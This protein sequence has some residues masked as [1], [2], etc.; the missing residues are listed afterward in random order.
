MRYGEAFDEAFLFASRLHRDQTRKQSE[1]P[2]ITHLLAVAALVGEAGGTETEIIAAL[3]HDAVEDQ[4]GAPIAAEIERRFGLDVARIVLACTDT[5]QT[6]KP[7]WRE[8][9]AAFLERLRQSDRSVGLV[10]AADKLH[11][12]R[13]TLEELQVKGESVWEKFTTGR[14]GSLWYYREVIDALESLPAL[15]LLPLLEQTVDALEGWHKE[16]L[17]D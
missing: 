11:N 2:Y 10:V 15:P 9:K 3:L 1:T 4:G 7:P 8:R 14:E 16:T 17:G 5:D 6:P 12:A 13:S